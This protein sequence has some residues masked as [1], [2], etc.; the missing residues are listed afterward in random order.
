MNITLSVK[1]SPKT[2][3]FIILQKRMAVKQKGTNALRFPLTDAYALHFK[4]YYS[5]STLSTGKLFNLSSFLN[6]PRTKTKVSMP[7]SMSV[8]AAAH[9][10][11][12][13]EPVQRPRTVMAGTKKTTSLATEIAMDL[14][15][16]PM[17]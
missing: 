16:A 8:T 13:T 11:Y 12:F 7:V 3:H 10:I 14:K 17:D 6:S 2:T 1:G 15:D 9:S 4:L 5:V